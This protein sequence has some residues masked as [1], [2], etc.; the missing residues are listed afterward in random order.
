MSVLEEGETMPELIAASDD[1][2]DDENDYSTKYARR[3]R[4]QPKPRLST[5]CRSKNLPRAPEHGT[6]DHGPPYRRNEALLVKWT[7]ERWYKV[8]M[9]SVIP[10]TIIVY[11]V[12]GS[13]EHV[14]PCEYKTRLSRDLQWFEAKVALKEE[15]NLAANLKSTSD[16][17]YRP[18]EVHDGNN[19]KPIYVCGVRGCKDQGKAFWTSKD[20]WMHKNRGSSHSAA[21]AKIDA[22]SEFQPVAI[23]ELCCGIDGCPK[24]FFQYASMESK[25]KHYL[26]QH[27]HHTTMCNGKHEYLVC[28]DK[29]CHLEKGFRFS[30]FHARLKHHRQFHSAETTPAYPVSIVPRRTS[31]TTRLTQP[32]K[33]AADPVTH[34]SPSVFCGDEAQ[35]EI[36]AFIKYLMSIPTTEM[37]YT[38]RHR[39]LVSES[40]I[41]TAKANTRFLLGMIALQEGV[42]T[43]TLKAVKS[44]A[45][46]TKL[47]NNIKARRHRGKP[48]TPARIYQ[49]SLLSLKILAYVCETEST[50][51]DLSGS[52]FFLRNATRE[53][54]RLAKVQER[55]S[56]H[57]PIERLIE[58][59]KWIPVPQLKILRGRVHTHL[60][61]ASKTKSLKV[62]TVQDALMYQDH[63]VALMSCGEIAV[64]RSQVLRAAMISSTEDSKK[65]DAQIYLQWDTKQQGYKLCIKTGNQTKTNRPVIILFPQGWNVYLK[66]WLE[67][68]RPGPLKFHS[69][70]IPRLF[71]HRYKHKTGPCNVS[72]AF[73]RIV[74]RYLGMEYG[75]RPHGMI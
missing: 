40:G 36:Q 24:Q 41:R 2:D 14:Y 7:D 9:Q 23:S 17:D 42:D 30:S 38:E 11:D 64:S 12:D 6:T 58:D 53:D 68:I 52:Y 73:R 57:I 63:L 49:L 15:S 62:M 37:R 48:I 29:L 18:M 65:I 46:M 39:T 31:S 4:S 45:I 55:E 74:Q 22:V 33:K 51:M 20:V 44:L 5:L 8:K 34:A 66:A 61:N 16:S 19:K 67:R 35:S 54:R 27:P 13:T 32:D 75:C 1:D 71:V 26:Q 59:K 28:N 50:T 69:A 21:I 3:R 10:D 47:R 43:P 72:G 70:S 60:L 25:K 56:L